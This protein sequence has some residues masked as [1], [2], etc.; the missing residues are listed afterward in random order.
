MKTWALGCSTKTFLFK[1]KSVEPG[2]V[3]NPS[4]FPPSDSLSQYSPDSVAGARC[5]GCP[6]PGV[7]LRCWLRR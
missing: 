1:K 6:Q 2:P 7:L 3:A 4:F 5:L